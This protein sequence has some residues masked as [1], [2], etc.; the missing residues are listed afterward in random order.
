MR[1][2]REA[3]SI[4]G[5]L[6]EPCKAGGPMMY[7]R[8]LWEALGGKDKLA[9]PCSQVLSTDSLSYPSLLRSLWLINNREYPCAP[10]SGI[11]GK[12]I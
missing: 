9:Y 10:R 11:R 6:K 5:S 2:E 3:E 1:E 8:D 4:S 7:H 12:R